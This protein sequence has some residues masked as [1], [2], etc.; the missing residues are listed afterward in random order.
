MQLSIVD[1]MEPDNTWRPG[2]INNQASRINLFFAKGFQLQYSVLFNCCRHRH[3]HFVQIVATYLGP[4]EYPF[5]QKQSQQIV[6]GFP[7]IKTK[8]GHAQLLESQTAESKVTLKYR[9]LQIT[10]VLQLLVCFRSRDGLGQA[11]KPESRQHALALQYTHTLK[12][13]HM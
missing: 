11:E 2:L 9:Y 3:E 12:Y 6:F 5:P 7:F 4:V 10:T 8:N 13:A 1:S